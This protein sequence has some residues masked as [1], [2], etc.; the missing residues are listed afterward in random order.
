MERY[1]PLKSESSRLADEYYSCLSKSLTGPNG[2]AID[3]CLHTAREYRTALRRQLEDLKR[4]A[5]SPF[6]RRERELA[7]RYLELVEHDLETLK[8]GEI[9]KTSQQRNSKLGH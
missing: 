9:P 4:L 6:I 2:P 1:L 3:E 7:S 8:Q 5:D